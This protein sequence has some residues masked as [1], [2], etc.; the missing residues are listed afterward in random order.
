MLGYRDY[1][2][3]KDLALKSRRVEYTKFGITRCA[4]DFTVFS[5]EFCLLWSVQKC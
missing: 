5:T 1:F 4:M 2:V 3:F